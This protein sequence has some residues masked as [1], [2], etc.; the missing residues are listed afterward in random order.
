MGVSADM[1]IVQ[2]NTLQGYDKDLELARQEKFDLFNMA[3]DKATKRSALKSHA[4][5]TAM[6]SPDFV[7]EYE[8]ALGLRNE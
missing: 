2:L 7:A 1:H 3:T 8:R 5:L 4:S 6:R